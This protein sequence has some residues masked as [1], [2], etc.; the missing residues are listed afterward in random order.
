LQNLHMT[1]NGCQAKT[2]RGLRPCT[3]PFNH[4]DKGLFLKKSSDRA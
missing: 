2:S 1:D 4:E 3:Y